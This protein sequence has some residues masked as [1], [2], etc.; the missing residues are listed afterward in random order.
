[1]FDAEVRRAGGRTVLLQTWS[2]RDEPHQQPDLD[3]AYDSVARELGA[4]LAPVGRVWARVRQ[5]SPGLDLYGADGSHPSAIGSYVLASTLVAILFPEGEHELPSSVSGHAVNGLG[6]V[7][8]R[9]VPRVDQPVDEAREVVRSVVNDTRRTGGYL[10]AAP[11]EPPQ[12]ASP[13]GQPV[14]EDQ[15]AGLWSGALT[16]YPAPALLDL[17]LR[18]D[19][20]GCRGEV[21]IQVPDRKHRYE[22][23]LAECSW[24]AGVLSFSVPTLPLPS[25]VDRFT[26]RT[27]EGRL[28][29]T[30]ERTGR[31]LGHAM[32]G[33][34]S[35]SRA[36]PRPDN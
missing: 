11:P 2:R 19:G 5:E 1:M 32:S 26:G 6:V 22:A 20:H 23:A 13:G 29:G 33:T 21:A 28:V 17:T 27:V 18:F 8:A 24:T 31:D 16:F 30:V 36:T 7:D 10:N 35:L 3:F 14:S 12:P 15:L 25:L 34:W 9:T 4:I